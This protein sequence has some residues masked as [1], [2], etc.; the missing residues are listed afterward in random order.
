[1]YLSRLRLNPADPRARR[2]L[3]DPYEMH[4]TLARVYALDATQPPAR[5]LWRK[6]RG[7][8]GWPDGTV[9]VQA[10]EPGRWAVLDEPAGYLQSLEPDKP[11]DLAAL[12][13]PGRCFRFRL[14]A[15]PT[16]TRQGKRYGLVREDEQLGWLNRQGERCGF[17]VQA[18]LCSASERLSTRQGRQGHQPGGG[19]RITV[20]SVLFEGVLCATDAAALQAALPRGLGHA[21]ALG[22]GLLSLAPLAD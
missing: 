18:A 11:V 13:Q 7:A 9:L 15:N 3:A 12:V 2:D 10:A 19:Q 5:F 22:L 20:Q 4:R 16:V 17:A 14:Q 8:G 21:K 1:M 6:E